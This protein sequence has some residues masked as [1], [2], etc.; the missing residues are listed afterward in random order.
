MIEY[1]NVAGNRL[2]KSARM[3]ILSN[4]A[5]TRIQSFL[6]EAEHHA[7]QSID[8]GNQTDAELRQL[9]LGELEGLPLET[10][11]PEPEAK[12]MIYATVQILNQLDD[13]IRALINR[14]YWETPRIPLISSRRDTWDSHQLV[15]WTGDK[16][17]WVELTINNIDINGHPFHLVCT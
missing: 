6:L 9:D 3:F 4:P 16:P 17:S 1:F 2:T 11:L 14:T 7:Q 13:D 8:S 15:P 12:F 5:L 10:L